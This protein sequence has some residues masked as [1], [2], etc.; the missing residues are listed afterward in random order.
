MRKGMLCS[1]DL[2]SRDPHANDAQCLHKLCRKMEAAA[3]EVG[4]SPARLLAN[5]IMAVAV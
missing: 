1:R 3:R 5:M 4:M 2:Q